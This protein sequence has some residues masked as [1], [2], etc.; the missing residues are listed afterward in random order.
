MRQV[1]AQVRGRIAENKDIAGI[2]GNYMEEAEK[3][4]LPADPWFKPHLRRGLF[5]IR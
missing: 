2:S 1:R 3:T 5:C 4:I